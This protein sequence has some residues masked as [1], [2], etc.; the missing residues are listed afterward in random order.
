M[1][2]PN[3]TAKKVASDSLKIS[4][5]TSPVLTDYFSNDVVVLSIS[6]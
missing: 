1:K 6:C 5:T 4:V 3:T 2:I